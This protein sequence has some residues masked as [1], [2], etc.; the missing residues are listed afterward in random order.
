MIHSLNRW[1]TAA[2]SA[3]NVVAALSIM[4]MMLLTC[5]DVVL[6]FFR[7]PI[8]GTYEIVCFLGALFVSFSLAQTSLQKGHI[9]VEFLVQKLSYKAQFFI[10]C[11]NE[12]ISAVLFFLITYQM[13]VSANSVRVSGEVSMT[14]QIPI[15]PVYYGIALGCGLLSIVL[16]LSFVK[17]LLGITPK[18]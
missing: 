11:I 8:P 10:Y 4:G 12:L 9:A 7:M 1:I 6:R 14:L 3:F 16:T 5:T 18:E 13:V 2:A 15:Y 17:S